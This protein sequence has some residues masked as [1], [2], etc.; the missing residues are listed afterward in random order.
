[1]AEV[2]V[3]A[4][5]SDEGGIFH[6]LKIRSHR[7]GGDAQ[8]FGK[9]GC[10][11]R[12]VGGQ[13][14]RN[15]KEGDAPPRHAHGAPPF[16]FQ[17]KLQKVWPRR[18]RNVERGDLARSRALPQ[19]GAGPADS[20]TIVNPP[21]VLWEPAFQNEPRRAG[22]LL[23]PGADESARAGLQPAPQELRPPQNEPWLLG[24]G[25]DGEKIGS[26][27]VG[28]PPARQPDFR[29]AVVLAGDQAAGTFEAE[30]ARGV[31]GAIVSRSRKDVK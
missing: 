2:H 27:Q 11:C 10:A 29:V 8:A 30:A 21:R 25:E 20:Q 5:P 16:V 26:A 13:E 31:H 3:A 15:S 4:I 19:N 6:P 23:Q 7:P 12:A 22:K 17:V 9:L 18:Q 14:Y 28:L 24:T 1:M